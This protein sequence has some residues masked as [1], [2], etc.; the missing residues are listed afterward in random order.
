ME[1]MRSRL[2]KF[3][4]GGRFITGNSLITVKPT[5]GK[6]PPPPPDTG[7]QTNL[8][9]LVVSLTRNSRPNRFYPVRGSLIDFTGD[10]FANAL[11]SKYSYQSY[12]FTFNKYVSLDEKQVLAYN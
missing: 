6:T 5:S 9:A 12:K 2:W 7:L 1:F 3:F 4:V 10:F 8:R 11:G